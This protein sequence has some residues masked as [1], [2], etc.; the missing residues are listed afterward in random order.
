[1]R[2]TVRTERFA[3]ELVAEIHEIEGGGYWAEVSRFP[4]CVAQAETIEALKQNIVQAVDDWLNGLPIK[5][6]DEARRLSQI[7]GTS[8]LV[9]ESFPQPNPYLPPASWIDED[10]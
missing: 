2:P 8:D 4:G 3:F 5:T 1:M 10:E 6:E 9:E 7:Q